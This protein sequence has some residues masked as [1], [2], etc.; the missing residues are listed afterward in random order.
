[1]RDWPYR[2]GQNRV[3][4]TMLGFGRE[5]FHIGQTEITVSDVIFCSSHTVGTA[6]GIDF[7]ESCSHFLLLAHVNLQI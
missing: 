1:M 4:N 2:R 5:A 7:R 6:K 3:L